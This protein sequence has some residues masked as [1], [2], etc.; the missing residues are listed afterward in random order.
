[1]PSVLAV[2]ILW[3][4]LI[5]HNRAWQWVAGAALA[6]G[7]VG[8]YSPDIGRRDV[9]N[10]FDACQGADYVYSTGVPSALFAK[11]YTGE[12]R[13]WPSA[14]DLNQTLPVTAKIAMGLQPTALSRLTGNVCL[15]AFNTPHT[16]QAEKDFLAS[17]EAKDRKLI[18]VSE[19]WDIHIYWLSLGGD[20][21][22]L[23]Y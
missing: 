10:V 13:I 22:G 2:V 3:A 8:F 16:S 4:W 7:L 17:L 18:H 19:T 6:I 14:N 21:N 11:Y 12:V 23:S 20:S 9:S 5:A 15:V 1:M